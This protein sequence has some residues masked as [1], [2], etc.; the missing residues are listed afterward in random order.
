M[1]QNESL[2][3]D[4]GKKVVVLRDHWGILTKV[5]SRPFM[6]TLKNHNNLWKINVP[7]E[8]QPPQNQTYF[9]IILRLNTYLK[10]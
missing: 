6:K 4:Q 8:A 3:T 1:P 10:T 5:C 2:W 7:C 9:E